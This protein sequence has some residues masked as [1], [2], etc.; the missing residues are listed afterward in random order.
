MGDKVERAAADLTWLITKVDK[1]LFLNPAIGLANIV[2][3]Q[4]S[5]LQHFYTELSMDFVQTT[6]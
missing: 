3:D 1:T 6:I 4:H 5:A 2:V